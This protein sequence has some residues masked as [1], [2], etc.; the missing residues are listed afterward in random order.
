[1]LAPMVVL[2]GSA[3]YCGW[4]TGVNKDTPSH[5]IYSPSTSEIGLERLLNFNASKLQSPCF[6]TCQWSCSYGYT[7]NSSSQS[8]HTRSFSR[9][10]QIAEN[11]VSRRLV[12]LGILA[13]IPH[14]LILQCKPPLH[15]SEDLHIRARQQLLKR[16][17]WI[18]RLSTITKCVLAA[19]AGAGRIRNIQ[20]RGYRQF[21]G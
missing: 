8:H 2:K 14:F 5:F 4:H 15:S 19:G 17:Y 6:Q 13:V 16:K 21:G 9:P 11:L 7:L 1:M 20:G 3:H 12:L 18:L 10:P